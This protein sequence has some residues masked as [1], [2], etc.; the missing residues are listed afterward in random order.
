MEKKEKENMRITFWGYM[1]LHG[2]F[3]GEFPGAILYQKCRET[4][5]DNKPHML[6]TAGGEETTMTSVFPLVN[7]TPKNIIHI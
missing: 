3:P 4:T 6:S 1:L 2:K 7:A 5:C